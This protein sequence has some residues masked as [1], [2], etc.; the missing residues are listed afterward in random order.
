MESTAPVT[1]VEPPTGEPS[2]LDDD[3]FAALTTEIEGV[4]F[5]TGK[6][7]ALQGALSHRTVTTDQARAL[8]ELF[9]FS[10]DRVD[11][12]VYLHPRVVDPENFDG[13]L[14]ALKFES[15]RQLVRTQLGLDG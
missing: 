12:L 10:R 14:S 4:A 6:M 9:S 2:A 11:A 5:T 13:L 3:G 1:A 15:D 7:Q 8:V